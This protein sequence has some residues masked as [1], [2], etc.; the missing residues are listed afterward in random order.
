MRKKLESKKGTSK[1]SDK[2]AI[3]SKSLADFKV[4]EIPLKRIQDIFKNS[5]LLR[6]RSE[7]DL[8]CTKK[9]IAEHIKNTNLLRDESIEIEYNK[10]NSEK[11]TTSFRSVRSS[12]QLTSSKVN[13]IHHS[14]QSVLDES[15]SEH[16]ESDKLGSASS[17]TS[18]DDRNTSYDDRNTS[19]E[20]KTYMDEIQS[21]RIS[22]ARKKG[23]ISEDIQT[24]INAAKSEDDI[25][26]QSETKLSKDE[27]TIHS[28]L[29]EY[30]SD[31]HTVS[32]HSQAKCTS[33]QSDTNKV[34]S[35]E[36]SEIPLEKSNAK[37]S[38]KEVCSE[39]ANEK[40]DSSRKLD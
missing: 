21:K 22:I 14:I 7:S 2:L 16:I 25:V 31:F 4:P 17:V 30:K 3:E 38:N 27:V 19:Y 23:S 29:G 34:Y 10:N 13:T 37:N 33:L 35:S 9:P 26:I 1:D 20:N 11:V 5:D 39:T 18:D 40:V 15:I 6:S 8:L 24:E 28:D 32:E 12:E 36:Y